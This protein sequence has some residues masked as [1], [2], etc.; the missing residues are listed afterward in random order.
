MIWSDS[1]FQHAIAELTG[2]IQATI[3][4]V[5][6]FVKPAPHSRRWWNGEL[7]TLKKQLN[8][9]NNQSYRFRA[10]TDHPIHVEHREARNKYSEAIKWAKSVHWQEFLD[11]AQGADIWMANRYISN[12]INDGGRQRIPTLKVTRPNDSPAEVSTNEEKVSV[13]HCCFFPPKPPTTSVP[14]SPNYPP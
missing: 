3:A 8:R 11:S 2:A 6:P 9:L 14:D 1:Q 7:S 13:F 12:P 4:A 5:V 10:L